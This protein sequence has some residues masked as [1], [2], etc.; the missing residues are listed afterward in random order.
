M[1]YRC[2]HA[3]ARLAFIVCCL[4]LLSNRL[5]AQNENESVG[6][7]ANHAFESGNFGENIDMLNG[8]LNL[9]TPIGPR[10]QVNSRLGYGV[11]LNY[12]SKVWDTTYYGTDWIP[13][14]QG[15]TDPVNQIVPINQGPFGIGFS[16]HFGRIFKDLQ[17]I[18]G[19]DGENIS[20]PGFT[21][22]YTWVSPDG[23]QHL[24]HHDPWLK[25]PAYSE[26]GP[27]WTRRATN[28]GSYALI[29]GPYTAGCPNGQTD[30]CF[31]VET[32]DG[33]T[34]T[35]EKKVDCI[36]PANGRDNPGQYVKD[37]AFN[38]SFCGWYT[39]KIEDLSTTQ[40]NNVQIAYD[41]RA[42]FK[43]AITSVTDSA[44]RTITFK[45]CEWANSGTACIPGSDLPTYPGTGDTNETKIATFQIDVPA[46]SKDAS[47]LDPNK[48]ATYKFQYE[49]TSVRRAFPSQAVMNTVDPVLK[50][51]RI[52]YPDYVPRNGS[53]A[54]PDQYSLYF[55]YYNT[56]Q[57]CP[58]PPGPIPCEWG[59]FD[60]NGDYGELT[61]RT[62]PLL[63]TKSGAQQIPVN[64]C[65]PGTGTWA[66]YKYTYGYYFYVAAYA[67]GGL[68]RSSCAAGK[69]CGS[70]SGSQ[71]DILTGVTRHVIS[72][73]IEMPQ[74]AVLGGERWRYYRTATSTTN[75]SKTIVKDPFLNETVYS[76]RGSARSQD[77]SNS[78]ATP[79]DGY[80][81]EW[82]DGANYRIDYYEGSE[83][84]GRLVRTEMM[85]QDADLYPPDLS[86]TKRS[87][88][89]VRVKQRSTRH[90]D[91]GN[92]ESRAIRNNWDGQGHWLVETVTGFEVD[93]PKTTRTLYRIGRDNKRCS[94]SGNYC[95]VNSDCGGSER[96]VPGAY[97][98]DNLLLEEVSD[99]TRVLTRVDNVYD[100]N[101]RLTSTLTRAV[102]GAAGEAYTP[103]PVQRKG[104]VKTTLT[105]SA[106]SGNVKQKTLSSDPGVAAAYTINYTYA[107]TGPAGS[108]TT[109][110]ECGGYL[111]GKKF[112]DA[113]F[114]SIKRDRDWNTGLIKRTYDTASVS[115]DYNYD[116]I[117]R[118]TDITPQGEDPTKVDYP[119]LTETT[120]T[121]GDSAS[122]DYIFTRYRYDTL[123]RQIV[124]Q[125]RPDD[126]TRG[127]PCQTTKYDVMSRVT[128]KSDW[129]YLPEATCSPG[130]GGETGTR[131]SFQETSTGPIDPFGRVR[132]E[133]PS[134]AN[135]TTRDKVIETKYFG[136]STEVRVNGVRG[137]NQKP[138]PAITTFYKDGLGRLVAVE[139]P[140]GSRCSVAGTACAT[141]TN[142]PSGE[143]C[144]AIDGGANAFYAYDA[145]DNLVRVDLTEGLSTQTRHFGYDG[146]GHLLLAENPENGTTVVSAYDAL[147]NP[148]VTQDA[149]GTIR[150]L[151]YDFAGRARHSYV[152]APGGTEHLVSENKYDETGGSSL[153]KLTTVLNYDEDGTLWLTENLKYNGLG[154]RLSE[155]S[156]VFKEYSPPG[157]LDFS[158]ITSYTY[159]TRGQ[160]TSLTYPI[161]PSP[162]RTRLPLN[163]AYKNGIL[164]SATSVPP[165]G[166]TSCPTTLLATLTYG[167]GGGIEQ[168][169]MPGGGRTWTT[170]DSRNRPSSIT[171]GKYGTSSWT[172]KDYE[173]GFAY[174][175]A[176][177]IASM[178]SQHSYA[179]DAANRLISAI[180]W[181]GTNQYIE[182]FSYDSLG[183][184]TRRWLSTN[185]A[186][187]EVDE[188]DLD[189]PGAP[190]SNRVVS[191][192][193]S[194]DSGSGMVSSLPVAF[195]Y[196]ANGNVVEGGRK[197]RPYGQ[198]VDTADVLR[199]DYSPLNQLRR[200]YRVKTTTS[201][202]TVSEMNRFFYD[203]R[204]NRIAKVDL[205]ADVKTYYVRD[206]SGQVLSE[207]Q[208]PLGDSSAPEWQ[209]DYLMVA[210]R[211]LGLKEN[212]RAQPVRN[213]RVT[214]NHEP[215]TLAWDPSAE[216]D[217]AS[218][219]V[220][221]RREPQDAS[222]VLIGSTTLTTYSDTTDYNNYQV[223]YYRVTAVDTSGYESGASAIRVSVNDDTA[224]TAPVLTGVAGDGT[225]TLN[226][227]AS[228]GPCGVPG[229]QIERRTSLTDA[230]TLLTS[231]LISTT[232]YVDIGL[233]NDTTYYYTIKAVYV[234]GDPGT[235]CTTQAIGQPPDLPLR[236]TDHTPPS[237]PHGVRAGDECEPS[238]ATQDSIRI[239]WDASL[240]SEN[241]TSYELYSATDPS[242]LG[243]SGTLVVGLP[244]T[245]TTYVHQVTTPTPAVTRYY[246][247]KAVDAFNNKSALSEIRSVLPRNR[248]MVPADRLSTKATDGQVTLSWNGAGQY[249]IYRKL[250]ASRSCGD[251]VYVGQA[252]C[253]GTQRF[254]DGGVPNNVAYDYAVTYKNGDVESTFS[255][256]ALAVPVHKPNFLKQCRRMRWFED[257]TFG[258]HEFEVTDL[259][260]DPPTARPYQPILAQTSDGTL[261]YLKGYHLYH[262]ELCRER[263]AADFVPPN[264]FQDNNLI[265][266]LVARPGDKSDPY[267][268]MTDQLDGRFEWEWEDPRFYVTDAV[269]VPRPEFSPPLSSGA[270]P[271][272][273]QYIF[274]PSVDTGQCNRASNVQCTNCMM[275][276]AVYKIY[277]EGT[278]LTAESDWPEYFDPHQETAGNRCITRL[279]PPYGLTE[280]PQGL[281]CAA[282]A[283]CDS[284]SL[285]PPR[286]VRAVAAGPGRITVSWELAIPQ[287]GSE[288]S[289]YYVYGREVPS[290]NH[291]LPSAE[292]SLPVLGQPL[293]FIKVGPGQTSVTIS[294]LNGSGSR[295]FQFNVMSFDDQGRV[296]QTYNGTCSLSGDP[297]SW[298]TQCPANQTCTQTYVSFAY[299]NAID[300]ASVKPVIWTLNDRAGYPVARKGIKIAWAGA[301]MC[302][303]SLNPTP[304]NACTLD[305]HCPT[306]YTCSG[307]PNLNGYRVYRSTKQAAPQT[308][309]C[310]LAKQGSGNPGGVTICADTNAYSEQ[311]SSGRD[312]VGGAVSPFYWDLNV[313]PNVIYYYR[314]TVVSTTGV[315]SNFDSTDIVSAMQLD[316]DNQVPPPPSGFKAWA[317]ASGPDML[318]VYVNWCKEPTP[319]PRA[320][321]AAL[322]A[323]S[324]NVYRSQTAGGP[325]THKVSIPAACLNEDANGNRTS[326]CVITG[327]PTLLSGLWV[328]PAPVPVACGANPCAIVDQTVSG[329]PLKTLTVLQQDATNYYYVV[330]AVGANGKESQPSFENAGY[331]NYCGT[332]TDC[333]RR[334]ADGNGE[335]LVCGDRASLDSGGTGF[336]EDLSEIHAGAGESQPA[337]ISSYRVIGSP[338]APPGNPY[339]PPARF[340]FYHLD[341]LGS[342]RAVLDVSANLVATHSYLPF[343]EERPNLPEYSLSDRNFTGHERD[344][345]S[346][347]DYMMARYYSSSLGRFMAV[348]PV[349]DIRPEDPQ[350]WNSFAYTRNN[351]IAYT[352]PSGTGACVGSVSCFGY[353]TGSTNSV[354]AD[355]GYDGAK[356]GETME[357]DSTCPGIMNTTASPFDSFDP[358]TW[359]HVIPVPDACK[360]A[361]DRCFQGWTGEY[362]VKSNSQ[363]Q[364]GIPP[365]AG[366]LESLTILGSAATKLDRVASI[367]GVE[368]IEILRAAETGGTVLRESGTVVRNAGNL[369]VYLK[370]PGLD[371][372]VRITTNPTGER[373]IS[374]GFNSVKQVIKWIESGRLLGP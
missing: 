130:F 279:F 107:P 307:A 9:T 355:P 170:Y 22:T 73:Q 135:E 225:V 347:L 157:T 142:C 189:T 32:L 332:G 364:M 126:P 28:D 167:A 258:P 110:D 165:P 216:V 92:R 154:G 315:E 175:G 228:T 275:P 255:S 283:S 232:T 7:R 137:P 169:K 214:T 34:Y 320:G 243:N 47:G 301:G 60:G 238:G 43:H 285:K 186:F 190:K 281:G 338:P 93:A 270:Y 77:Q 91:D 100:G 183:N 269:Q 113:G 303:Q 264:E 266:E 133:I 144:M 221:R 35:L 308:E 341:H 245:P 41:T 158:E 37:R 311:Y 12:N 226:W 95:T 319:D 143:T 366:P 62:L 207:F 339:N 125:R 344:R 330:T 111:T 293:P 132:R 57:F 363:I 350:S 123:G 300:V 313:T 15:Q 212:L 156:H 172:R 13:R 256:P 79:E 240:E 268:L 257:T 324:F 53:P 87:K 56:L 282:P 45:N 370:I 185:N 84:T 373:I 242:T 46:F 38:S 18:D 358:R 105:Y 334:D 147:G 218:Y 260:W 174:D 4:T 14:E 59:G 211:M 30:G 138:F 119:S 290:L 102:P 149:A 261:G 244:A 267:L 75:P 194:T 54:A 206:Q 310:L 241:V 302:I 182:N 297:C 80:A 139:S 309:W 192:T 351:P 234:L 235:P 213:L 39:T 352:D 328:Y 21:K 259:Q 196:D 295:K 162:T 188:F 155:I 331:L 24:I 104:D 354:G 316:Y 291:T 64:A 271:W 66:T 55:G 5:W 337:E 325:Y 280:S 246:A 82:N 349:G 150:R 227:T 76:Y 193:T 230:P 131:Y 317:P 265:R 367:L 304:A 83:A 88:D 208:R 52:D 36:T 159:D 112:L 40:A 298:S 173:T 85:E 273:N 327:S 210:G 48:I 99:G 109:T 348:D 176:G 362:F 27:P 114:S 202:A 161:E 284:T 236:P 346:G 115:T 356:T 49:L 168:I 329:R 17:F 321:D 108:C 336:G 289:G 306:G 286:N 25:P 16:G 287:D 122:S 217:W 247:L 136:T 312:L 318:G 198:T 222:F 58:S 78:G 248:S 1:G 184:M 360:D 314:V 276:K 322:P 374:A 224:P 229:Y 11:T 353:G 163:Y 116:S 42:K 3:A 361:P 365:L 272:N 187:T 89:N 335:Y 118:L 180:D 94:G 23:S 152:L 70:G 6:F 209:K 233:A 50:L 121:Q 106:A 195:T 342:V 61:C 145:L 201:P 369:N 263:T 204:G 343:G 164:I 44:G 251:Y 120:V 72:K 178:G 199:Y 200:T 299:P 288:I 10:F 124:Q 33:L 203:S 323:G 153:G 179:Y 250:N 31:K 67:M 237:P 65:A 2:V 181:Q 8:G 205:A 368:S 26:P 146:L 101:A 220:Y 98:T 305:S 231:E 253:T 81:P 69:V 262:Q 160:L 296:S 127:Y 277:A 29:T 249:L 128:F 219:K 19:C 96:C 215:V 151:D 20:C 129:A 117:G 166:C 294:G 292:P 141:D 278:W 86:H 103:N 51:V 191:R 90:V 223:V 71:G 171:A 197:W 140:A 274:R 134:D 372:Y 252:C 254:T 68:P 177:N 357:I 359:A 74:G 239:T 63:R 345:E 97:T 340:I 148:L 333:V 326:R 371:R